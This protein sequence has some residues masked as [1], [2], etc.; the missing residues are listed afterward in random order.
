MKT[1]ISHVRSSFYTDSSAL[2]PASSLPLQ[3]CIDGGERE[4]AELSVEAYNST[5]LVKGNADYIVTVVEIMANERDGYAVSHGRVGESI[6]CAQSRRNSS[7][8][9]GRYLNDVFTRREA[10]I[11]SNIEV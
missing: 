2:S 8:P 5:R 9:G 3:E 4:T 11:T 7:H 10:G 6:R 1:Q